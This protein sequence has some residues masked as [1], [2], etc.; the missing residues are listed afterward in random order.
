MGSTMVKRMDEFAG[1]CFNR[2]EPVII[3]TASHSLWARNFFKIYLPKS[4]EH[5]AKVHKMVNCSTVAF[6]IEKGVMSYDSNQIGYRVDETSITPMYLGF[7]KVKCEMKEPSKLKL[8]TKAALAK[9][10][11]SKESNGNSGKNGKDESNS[12]SCCTGRGS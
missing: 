7:E 4:S 12:F 5:V 8:P 1:W 6:T 2:P 9:R 11:G 3:V 10:N